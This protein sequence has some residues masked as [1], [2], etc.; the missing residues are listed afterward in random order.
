MNKLL[1]LLLTAL[2]CPLAQAASLEPGNWQTTVSMTMPGMPF[3]PPPRTLTQCVSAQQA[4]RPM[5]D[6]AKEMQ[7]SDCKL[8]D[9]TFA[10]GKGHWKMTCSGRHASTGEGWI[11]YENSKHYTSKTEMIMHDTGGGKM[12][13]TS[14]SKWL[15]PCTP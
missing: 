9:F 6:V 3:T 13:I 2:A 14:D 11:S 7:G 10:D 1:C 12:T 5:Q 15:G 8:A 4:S